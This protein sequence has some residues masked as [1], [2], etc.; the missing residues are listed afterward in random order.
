MMNRRDFLKGAAGA[1]AAAFLLTAD[2]ANTMLIKPIPRPML[3]T[4][5]TT[6]AGP[7]PVSN[8]PYY[9]TILL[10]F[11]TPGGTTGSVAFSQNRESRS[12]FISD[13]QS[14]RAAGR[15]VLLSVGGA[16]S[17]FSLASTSN[18]NEF[19]ASVESIMQNVTGQL[20]GIDWEIEGGALYPTQMIYIAQAL[21]AKFPGFQFTFPPAPHNSTQMSVAKQLNQARALDVCSPQFYDLS[22]L[23]TDQERVNNA[24]SRMKNNWI[25]AM[26]GDASKCG[27]GFGLRPCSG[28]TM[29]LS[30][31]VT[32]WKT[33]V[34]KYPALRGAFSWDVSCDKSTGYPFAT[35][36]TGA[37]A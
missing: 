31:T 11:A 26:G 32:V 21:R 8:I 14:C 36:M 16:G 4:Y 20:D 37:H 5:W 29:T 6:W 34:Q 13:I 19:I 22:G 9:N 28:E 23:S 1:S 12:D 17:Y 27:L 30:A 25:P 3:A 7:V 24:V 10:A 35:T 15:P 18:A 33:L 2:K